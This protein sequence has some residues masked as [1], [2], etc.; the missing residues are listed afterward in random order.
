[1]KGRPMRT[2]PRTAVRRLAL[3]RAMSETGSAAASTA[4]LD[5]VFIRSGGSAVWLGLTLLLTHGVAGALG[6]LG[7]VLGDR[8]DRKRVMILSD[9]AGSSRRSPRF[10]S[11]RP[12]PRP[13]RM[14][15]R[16]RR[17]S[18]GPTA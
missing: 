15:W 8:F 18:R 10:R 17:R 14:S 16:S 6:P 4:L 9:L 13:S 11:G 2:P 12:P 5:A 3:A 1:M 7:G